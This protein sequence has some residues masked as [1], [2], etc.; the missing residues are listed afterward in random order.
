L[1][2]LTAKDSSEPESSARYRPTIWAGIHYIMWSIL[3]FALWPLAAA[4]TVVMKIREHE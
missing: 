4:L 2:S 3:I 1:P